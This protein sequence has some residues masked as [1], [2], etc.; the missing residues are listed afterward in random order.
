MSKLQHLVQPALALLLVTAFLAAAQAQ[1]VVF[2]SAKTGADGNPCTLAAPCRSLTFAHSTVAANGRIVV[3]DSGDY[4][5]LLITKSVT[6]E[7]APGVA[8]VVTNPV[9]ATT[10]SIHASSTDKVVLRGLHLK[11]ST[12]SNSFG[13]RMTAGASLLVDRCVVEGFSTNG[14]LITSPSNFALHNSSVRHN[15]VGVD[16]GIVSSGVQSA[17]I[18]NCLIDR[19]SSHGIE[20]SPVSNASLRAIVRNTKIANNGGNGIRGITD[21]VESQVN[22]IVENVTIIGNSIGIRVERT[23]TEVFVTKSTIVGNVTGLSAVNLGNIFTALNNTV[24]GNTSNGSFTEAYV[25]E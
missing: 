17:T 16:I 9:A 2:I 20:L 10:I 4:S 11:G 7:S 6:I 22:C 15:G 21:F 25:V 14:I 5:D 13:L 8:A 19:N 1:T 23:G 24:E 12:P 3:M 18:D